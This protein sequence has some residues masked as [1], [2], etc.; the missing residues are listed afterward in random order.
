MSLLTTLLPS[1]VKLY[2]ERVKNKHTGVAV[3]PLAAAVAV[4][5]GSTP[6]DPTSFEGLL[7]QVVTGAIGLYFL[8]KKDKE[9]EK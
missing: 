4:M 9:E 2:N 6:V 1:L 5:S 3:A 7:L 8:Y